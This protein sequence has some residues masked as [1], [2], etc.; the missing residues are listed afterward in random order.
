MNRKLPVFTTSLCVLTGLITSPVLLAQVGPPQTAIEE[1]LVLGRLE[2]AAQSIVME[3]MTSETVMDIIGSDQIERIGDS[4]VAAALKRVPGVTLVDNKFVYIRGL[5]ERYSSSILNGATVPSPDLTRNVLPLD[6]FPSSILQSVAIQKGYTPDMPASFGG[7]NIDIRTKGIPDSFVFSVSLGGGLE[8][9]S[10]TGY[11]YAGGSDDYFG[12]DDGT[13]GNSASVDAALRT[14]FG[15]IN[16]TEGSLDA[17]AIEATA[18][19]AGSAISRTEAESINAAFGTSVYRDLDIGEQNS[20]LQDMSIGGRLGNLYLLS[21][22]WEFG[23]LSS[24]NYDNS[25]RSDER[26]QRSYVDPEEEF[27]QEF[28]TTENVSITGTA[29]FGLRWRDDHELTS[30]NLF[31]RNTDDEVGITNIFNTTSPFSTGQGSRNYDYRYEQRELQI[32]QVTGRHALGYDTQQLIGLGESFL[33]DMEL[34]WFYSDATA[35]TAIPSETNIFASITRDV[36]TNEISSSRLTQGLRMVDVRYTDLD[37]SVESTGF[38]V[39]LPVYVGSWEMK[40]GGGAKFDRKVRSYEQLDL[41]IGSPTSAAVGTLSGS[42]SDALSATNLTNPDYD[43]VVTYQSGLSRSYIA[44]ATTDAY[45]GQV[46][47]TWNYRWRIA[48]GARYEEYKQFTSPWQPYRVNG[49]QLLVDLSNPAAG[50]QPEGLYYEDAIYP[51]IALTYSSQNFWADD[52]NLRFAAS[53]TVVRPDLREVSNASYM[54]P[55]TDI[56]VRGN[57][58]AVPSDLTNYDVRGEWFF[59]NGDNLSL[60]LFYK[61]ITNPIEYFQQAGAED[62]ITATIENAA[63]GESKGVEVEWLKSLDFMGD[64]ASQFFLSGNMTLAS[65][66]ISVGDDLLVAATNRTRPL[67]GAS[68]KVLNIQLGFDANSGMHAATIGYNH[69]GERLFAAGTGDLPDSFEQPFSALDLSYSYFV[70]DEFTLSLKARNLLDEDVQI[71]QGDVDVYEQTVGQSF[72]LD[73]KY[74][75]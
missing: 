44:A 58:D 53:E 66:E 10:D 69:Y 49:S 30:T 36:D 62:T 64:F 56:I 60:S 74:D 43:Y 31:L 65:S 70:S 48:A 59:S 51:S 46:D 18:V 16:A 4:T 20:S 13:R 7:G 15:S 52:F 41:S 39:S 27:Q 23:F 75:F 32:Q 42:I 8:T 68:D 63:T 40:F 5:G 1:V 21:E 61:D 26:I 19:R 28:R 38:E 35:A 47:V 71:S 25:S 54:D 34:T 17:T 33:N 57:P 12:E 11:E 72:S 9:D 73:V 22:D 50:E 29:N 67:R 45:F 2:S 24:I 14:Y 6:I 55:L 37:D 3:R